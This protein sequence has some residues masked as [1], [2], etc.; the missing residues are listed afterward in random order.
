MNILISLEE[1]FSSCY[2]FR[3]HVT[4]FIYSQLCY[5]NTIILKNDIKLSQLW[6]LEP[7]MHEIAY[8]DTWIMT[9]FDRTRRGCKT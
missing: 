2:I 6:K 4:D 1:S 5:V 7:N 3:L 9:F 8:P